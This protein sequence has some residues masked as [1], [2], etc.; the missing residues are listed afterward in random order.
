MAGNDLRIDAETLVETINFLSTPY[1]IGVVAAPRGE[2]LFRWQEEDMQGQPA[3][4]CSTVARPGRRGGPP[5]LPA[6]PW[7]WCCPQRLQQRLPRR[8][9]RLAALFAA[10]LGGFLETTLNV[11]P[12]V[13]PRGGG[14]RPHKQLEDTASASPWASQRGGARRGVGPCSGA[15]DEKTAKAWKRIE[16]VLK[17]AAWMTCWRWTTACHGVLRRLRRAPLPD[18][19]GQPV[20]AE[21]RESAPGQPAQLH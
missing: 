18:P 1:V 13:L 7:M 9:P 21:L 11:R 15:G 6:A 20:H 16:R 3:Q 10:R 5:L 12:G 14:R 4:R 2:P 19:E 17:D 8:G